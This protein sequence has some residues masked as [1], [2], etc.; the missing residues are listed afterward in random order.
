M[1]KWERGGGDGCA[2]LKQQAEQAKVTVRYG[3]F[4]VGNGREWAEI[5]TQAGGSYALVPVT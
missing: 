1:G 3:R 2:G 5:D 4:D